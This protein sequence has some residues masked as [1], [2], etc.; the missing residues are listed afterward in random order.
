L[1][2]VVQSFE[3]ESLEVMSRLAPE[4]PRAYLFFAPTD[5]LVAAG[6]LHS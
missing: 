2:V 1:R 6:E 3:L 4:V 5:P